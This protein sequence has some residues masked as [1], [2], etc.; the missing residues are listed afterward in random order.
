MLLAAAGVPNVASADSPLTS[1]PFHTAYPEEPLV[2]QAEQQVLMPDIAPEISSALRD[3]SV[4]SEVRAAII[5]A[6]GW[7][8]NVG[9]ED[10]LAYIAAQLG[11]TPEMVALTDL[12]V[13]DAFTLGYMLALADYS[14]LEPIGGPGEVQG[15][16]AHALLQLAV[17]AAPDDFTITL[18]QFLVFSQEALHADK[19]CRVHMLVDHVVSDFAGP[20]NMKQEAIDI[21]TG[22]T[23]L[24]ADDCPDAACPT[25][26]AAGCC[27]QD[28]DCG[29]GNVCT[30]ISCDGPSGNC[31][32][33]TA[34]GCCVDAEDCD[35][36]DPCTADTCPTAG[37]A[38]Q[39]DPI[40]ACCMADADCDDGDVCVDNGCQPEPAD[41]GSASDGVGEDDGGA[42]EDDDGGPGTSEGD[43]AP[44]AGADGTTGGATGGAEPS[45]GA[46]GA[47]DD[48]AG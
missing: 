36:D 23:G 26:E 34:A 25:L 5:N 1:T 7:Q 8:T 41:D 31:E 22:Y 28:S 43:G 18:I 40:A 20:I 17:D 10:Q 2:V 12:T 37:A 13:P 15:A 39:H 27:V 48:S 42:G 3:P 44:G 14:D 21:I 32:P 6:Y 4:Q 11:T 45:D 16:D 29:G 35:D 24:Y 30:S 19:W 47:D 9:P 38:C 33:S 46:G